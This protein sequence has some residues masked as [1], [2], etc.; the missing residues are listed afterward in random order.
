VGGIPELIE[1]GRHGLLV[2]PANPGALA[3]A[4][5]LLFHSPELAAAMG[6]AARE[7]A[8]S[9]FSWR[10]IAERTVSVYRMLIEERMQA[11]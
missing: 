6:R 1:S 10:N 3:N 9:V 2:E 7:R 11:Y 4:I 5:A 8:E